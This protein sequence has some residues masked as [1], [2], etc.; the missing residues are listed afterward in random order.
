MFALRG[1]M[2]KRTDQLMKCMEDVVDPVN[3]LADELHTLNTLVKAG[4]VTDSK[5]LKTIKEVGRAVGKEVGSLQRAVT[6]HGK[7]MIKVSEALRE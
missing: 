7:M 1:E 3:R 6:A 2:K 5:T 4:K